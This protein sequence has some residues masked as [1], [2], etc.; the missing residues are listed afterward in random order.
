MTSLF[1]VKNYLHGLHGFVA[2][3]QKSSLQRDQFT[4]DPGKTPNGVNFYGVSSKLYSYIVLY[5]AKF[6]VKS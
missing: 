5:Y 3:S 4:T 1:T 6:G 2:N